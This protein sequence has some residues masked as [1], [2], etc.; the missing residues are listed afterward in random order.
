[1]NYPFCSIKLL[2][3][4]YTVTK[5]IWNLSRQV[6]DEVYAEFTCKISKTVRRQPPSHAIKIMQ[7]QTV[8]IKKIQNEV[9]LYRK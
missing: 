9:T 6:R 2:R 3:C 1:M 7:F 4:F 8:A 5:R